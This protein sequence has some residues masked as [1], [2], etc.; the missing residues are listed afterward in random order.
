MA[1]YMLA[2]LT[3]LA[4]ANKARKV[5]HTNKK[6][7]YVYMGIAEIPFVLVSG[8]RYY[9]GTDYPI[10][11]DIFNII[12]YGGTVSGIEKGYLWAN[13]IVSF[14][15]SDY[16]A[17]IFVM[18]VVTVSCYFVSIALLSSDVLVSILIW[19]FS[20]CFFE[21]MNT[22]RQSL[23]VSLFLFSLYF[24]YNKKWWWYFFI[25]LLASYFHFSAVILLF[26]YWMVKRKSNIKWHMGLMLGILVLGQ[27]LNKVILYLPLPDRYLKYFDN[28]TAYTDF[29]LMDFAIALLVW[30]FG[31]YF[32]RFVKADQR[33]KYDFFLN[34]QFIAVVI[35]L[36]S[37]NVPMVYRVLQYFI[38]IPILMVPEILSVSC[39]ASNR[40]II[41]IFFSM[42]Y[43]LQ[44]AYY[45]FIVQIADFVKYT[46]IFSR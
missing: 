34:L 45:V 41:K 12:R 29:R 2:L 15:T 27:F 21:S 16:Q 25:I 23:A 22:V 13:R 28:I 38:Y 14:F 35:S 20:L 26:V 1:V 31:W 5:K 43:I 7:Y 39:R 18:A 32:H 40:N 6:I 10:Y 24:L 33:E 19:V 3:A 46:S 44:W 36:I 4:V 30:G 11:R 42:A 37:G 9:V 8:L 17:I